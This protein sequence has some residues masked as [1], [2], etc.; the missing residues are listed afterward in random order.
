MAKQS[1]KAILK[2]LTDFVTGFVNNKNNPTGVT[3][4]QVNA[5][6][7]TELNNLLAD[8][9]K[10]DAV[11]IAYWGS[12]LSDHPP[13]TATSGSLRID[14]AVTVMMAGYRAVMPATTVP[15]T[16]GA[17]KSTF[18]YLKL[19]AGVFSY[20]T[21]ATSQVE[22]STLMYLGRVTDT[23]TSVVIDDMTPVIQIAGYRLSNK[24]RGNAIPI[25]DS[26]GATQW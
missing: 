19:N 23:G 22:T 14:A 17:G 7:R 13:V 9:L 25:T 26:N 4:A 15:V 10:R 18:I 16:A 2:T 24:R 12:S 11:P 5:Y 6:T 20:T 21:F 3:A 8:K 1:L